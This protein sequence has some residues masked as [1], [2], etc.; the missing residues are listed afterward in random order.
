MTFTYDPSVPVGQIRLLIPDRDSDTAFFEDEELT[1]ILAFEG[2]D[3]RRAAAMALETM[4]SN[5][6]Y[7]MKAVRILG[8]T[9]NGHQTAQ[10]LMNRAQT[11]RAQAEF[12]DAAAGEGFDWIEQVPTDFAARERVFNER[13]RHSDG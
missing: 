2:N 9:T 12:A 3:V 11:L 6:A 13:L 10:A 5:E 8:L 4:A 1:A 7:V